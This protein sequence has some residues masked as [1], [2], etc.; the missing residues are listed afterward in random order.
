MEK[1]IQNFT[2]MPTNQLFDFLIKF[3]RQY[4]SRN[5]I[6]SRLYQYIYV[7]GDAECPVA[8]VAHL[9]TVFPDDRNTL[10]LHDKEYDVM[11]ATNG[12]G[13]DDRRGVFAIYELVKKG[14]RP[15][16]IFTTGEE[17]GGIGAQA[18]IKDYPKALTKNLKY[19]IE[20]DRRGYNDCV[21]YDCD[22][23]DFVT[24]IENFG[25]KFDVGSF[26]D[27]SFI[28]PDWKIAGVNL[29]VG[30]YREHSLAEILFVQDL[31]DTISKVELMLLDRQEAPSFKY[32]PMS[33]KKME[34]LYF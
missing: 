10:I 21:F 9:D 29:S 6:H 13:F 24:Y 22:N 25:F 27:I 11:F 2:I 14:Y 33:I 30:Y 26:T 8:L 32:I 17:R 12:A 18:L 28:C 15:S 4:Y 31:Y 23:P 3:L 16:I 34:E 5:N 7:C 1:S 19:I 20:L